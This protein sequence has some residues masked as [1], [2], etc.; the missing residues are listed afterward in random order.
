MQTTLLD[1]P[2]ELLSE[3]LDLRN[4]LDRASLWMVTHSRGL[5]DARSIRLFSEHMEVVGGEV[6]IRRSIGRR[7]GVPVIDEALLRR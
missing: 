6:Q 7:Y 3:D 1:L 2:D 4:P 5:V